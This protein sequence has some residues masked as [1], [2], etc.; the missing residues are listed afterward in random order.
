MRLNTRGHVCF[1]SRLV[2]L[3]NLGERGVAD[4]TFVLFVK[5][6]CGLTEEPTII[7]AAALELRI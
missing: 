5:C 7:L 3:R 2:S 6:H 4:W 1:T